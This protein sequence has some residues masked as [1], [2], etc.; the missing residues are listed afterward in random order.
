[1]TLRKCIITNLGV[2]NFCRF[3]SV[4][5]ISLGQGNKSSYGH[6]ISLCTTYYNTKNI[7]LITE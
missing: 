5:N 1:M 3:S 6:E 7:F 4:S 2:N